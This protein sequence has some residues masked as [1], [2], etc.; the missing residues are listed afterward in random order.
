MKDDSVNKNDGSVKAQLDQ[1]QENNDLGA[2]NE[3]RFD[4]NGNKTESDSLRMSNFL[5]NINLN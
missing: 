4:I 5:R 3:D 2:R 1:H